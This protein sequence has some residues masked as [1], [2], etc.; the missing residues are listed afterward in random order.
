MPASNDS[1]LDRDGLEIIEL[2]VIS[3][4]QI[5]SRV[6][7]ILSHLKNS[8]QANSKQ[9]LI[10]LTAKATVANKLITI[11]EI[12]KRQLASEQINV[13]QYNAMGSEIVTVKPP[14]TK[15]SSKSEAE[16]ED[17]DEDKDA[18]QTMAEPDKVR[19][20]PVLSIYLSRESVNTL[21]QRFGE[22]VD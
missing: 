19:N 12:A 21:K 22:Q 8:A 14:N 4:T 18:F 13:F 3:S 2:N 7:A 11:V 20:S 15:K 5:S 6:T 10:R 9:P 1:P 17:V 16:S